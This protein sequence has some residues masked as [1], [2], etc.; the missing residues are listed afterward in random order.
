[1]APSLY[2]WNHMLSD[3]TRRRA[4]RSLTA[5]GTTLLLAL[6]FT[7]STGSAHAGSAA[8][9]AGPGPYSAAAHGATRR[10]TITST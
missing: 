10:E 6:G 8:A 5:A 1:M 3:P 4:R 9:A 2:D 7:A